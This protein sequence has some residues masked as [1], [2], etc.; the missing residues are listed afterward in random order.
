MSLCHQFDS[1]LASYLDGQASDSDAE[2]LERHAGECERCAAVLE[3]ATRPTLLLPRE[4]AP[5]MAVRDAVLG[6]IAGSSRGRL[7]ARWF[8]PTAIAAGLLVAFML[9]QPAPK[10]AETRESSNPS[11]A[12]AADRAAY[13]LGVLDAAH[14]EL[15]QA[16]RNAPGDQ[17]IADALGRLES[18]RR[19]LESLV[20]EF[21]S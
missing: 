8:V 17:R 20:L 13:D 21:E 18:Q 2:W 3:S 14:D 10:A 4:I 12:L 6:S 7:R 5:P 1:M 15:S 11:A 19:F 16:L 9:L